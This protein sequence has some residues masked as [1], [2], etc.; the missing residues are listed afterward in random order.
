MGE[1]IECVNDVEINHN[2]M[3]K[4][5]WTNNPFLITKNKSSQER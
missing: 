5:T 2:N 4:I 1:L 3:G